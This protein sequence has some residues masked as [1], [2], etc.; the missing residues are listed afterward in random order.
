MNDTHMSDSNIAVICH[1]QR[2]YARHS[3]N[4]VYHDLPGFLGQTDRETPIE[5]LVSVYAG[6]NI[7]QS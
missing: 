2:V 1:A 4:Y 7:R 3:D 6:V 5:N